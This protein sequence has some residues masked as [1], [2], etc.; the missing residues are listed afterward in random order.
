VIAVLE[1]RFLVDQPGLEQRQRRF[2][3][4]ARAREI[5]ARAGLRYGDLN[6]L[7][8]MRDRTPQRVLRIQMDLFNAFNRVNLGIPVN[9]INSFNFGQSTFTI[10]TPRV[11][12]FAARFDF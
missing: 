1:R 11:I 12:Q 7:R 6:G 5:Y 2:L 10:A 9:T 3:V 8:E 4:Q